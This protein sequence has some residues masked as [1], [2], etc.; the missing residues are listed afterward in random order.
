[1]FCALLVVSYFGEALADSTVSDLR[2]RP[3]F[4]VELVAKEPLVTDPVAFDWGSD[5]RL[6]VVEMHLGGWERSKSQLPVLLGLLL[7]AH[8]Q[9]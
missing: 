8:N 5:G 3:G 4:V 1:M 9:P 2:P 7:G 6:W